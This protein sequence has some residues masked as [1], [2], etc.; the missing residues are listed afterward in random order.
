MDSK[1]KSFESSQFYGNR[2][3]PTRSKNLFGQ[4]FVIWHRNFICDFAIT[5]ILQQNHE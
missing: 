5:A 1:F 3:L 2:D 4:R